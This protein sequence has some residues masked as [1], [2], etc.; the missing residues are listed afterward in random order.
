MSPEDIAR[1]ECARLE[2]WSDVDQRSIVVDPLKGGM[3]NSMFVCRS[4]GTLPLHALSEVE[5]IA[6]E[7]GGSSIFR[8][9]GRIDRSERRGPS[10]PRDVTE[11]TGPGMSGDDILR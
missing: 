5:T 10:V 11:V 9:D 3:S 4:G 6:R 8:S 2:S 1:R 7:H